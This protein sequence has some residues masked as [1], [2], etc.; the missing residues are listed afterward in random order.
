MTLTGLRRYNYSFFNLGP[1]WWWV[2]NVTPRSLY[3]REK[4]LIL[5]AQEDGWAPGAGLDGCIKSRPEQGLDHRTVQSVASR[6][7]DYK[8]TAHDFCY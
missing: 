3:P 6:Y 7:A 5:T 1:R 8:I 4:D 2:I